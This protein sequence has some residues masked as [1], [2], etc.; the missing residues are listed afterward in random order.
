MCLPSGKNTMKLTSLVCSLNGP[1]MMS[2]FSASLTLIIL[3]CDA[4]KMLLLSCEDATEVV[5]VLVCPLNGPDMMS[6]VSASHTLVVLSYDSETMH[7]PS[8]ENATEAT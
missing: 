4:E 8:G 7:L 5:T 1:D 2:P 6:P 3:S